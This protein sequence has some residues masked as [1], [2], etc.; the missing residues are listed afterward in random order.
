MSDSTPATPRPRPCYTR[1]YRLL[2]RGTNINGETLLAT[3]YLNHFNEVVMLIELLPGAPEFMADV[4]AWR[5]KGYADHF[6]D[7]GFVHKAL[8][9]A[10]YD[11]SPAVYREA[12]DAVVGTLDD[13][14]L[15]GI[16]ALGDATATHAAEAID[17]IAVDLTATARGYIDQASAIINGHG[18]K[19]RQE[20]IDALFA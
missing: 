4:A 6:R 1:T 9:I 11:Q 14:L 19:T 17:R 12:F 5:P 20:E 13:I 16:V 2:A 7:G 8:A 3:D 10:A 15:A 18:A